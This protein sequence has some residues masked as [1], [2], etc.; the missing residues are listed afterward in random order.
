M[1]KFSSVTFKGA[2]GTGYDFDV[3]RT[4]N[5]WNDGIA[6]VYFVTRRYQRKNGKYYH[7]KL[8]I[9]KSKD[10]K[11]EVTHHH[12]QECFDQHK[13]NCICIHPE[14]DEKRRAAIE[15]DLKKTNTTKCNED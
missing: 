13:A 5:I 7:E 4:D 11:R 12:K 3:Y 15:A 9:G 1:I 8:Y 10:I 14:P 2:S 6:A